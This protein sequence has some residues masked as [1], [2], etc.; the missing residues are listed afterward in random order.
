MK[1]LTKSSA[2]LCALIVVGLGLSTS[3]N[4]K[5]DKDKKK[6]SPEKVVDSGSRQSWS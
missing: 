5:D 4:A 6:D 1:R 3:V 2:W